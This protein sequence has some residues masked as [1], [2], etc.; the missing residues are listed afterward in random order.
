[1]ITKN[2]KFMRLVRKTLKMLDDPDSNTDDTLD[3]SRGVMEWI[4]EYEKEEGR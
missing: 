2:K 3:C 1:M 4:L